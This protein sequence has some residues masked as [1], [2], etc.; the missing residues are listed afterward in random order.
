MFV[1]IWQYQVKP[2]ENERFEEIYSSKGLW[3]EL[4][5]RSAGYLGTEL[6]HAEASGVVRVLAIPLAVLL[7][8]STRAQPL[9]PLVKVIAPFVVAVLV[10]HHIALMEAEG[11]FIGIG[12]HF[13]D[14][15][16]VIPR[17]VQQ[18]DP[19]MTPQRGVAVNAR[20]VGIVAAEQAGARGG[21]ERR[22]NE[23]VVE[24]D[25]FL[26]QAIQV[27]GI[28][29]GKSQAADGVETLLVGNDKDDI[30][31]LLC[32]ASVPLHV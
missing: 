4:F 15:D 28:H 10:F 29:V 18:F 3:T 27:G 17:V 14:V 24:A 23:A 32:H 5:K 25:P 12:V 20:G 16:A 8:Q 19:R 21:A 30:G 22:G 13:A 7:D 1:I 6:I 2:Q 11:R 26:H 31:P 9:V